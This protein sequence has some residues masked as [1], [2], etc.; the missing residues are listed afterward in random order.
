MWEVLAIGTL[1]EFF[2]ITKYYTTRT[3]DLQNPPSRVVYLFNKSLPVNTHNSR[4][5]LPNPC[6]TADTSPVPSLPHNTQHG[7]VNQ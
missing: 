6:R 3:H 5:S 7:V 2:L 1:S 4:R